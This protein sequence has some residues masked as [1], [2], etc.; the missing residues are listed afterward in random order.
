LQMAIVPSS[1]WFV[2]REVAEMNRNAIQQT[3][4]YCI[5]CFNQESRSLVI[6]TDEGGIYQIPR[7][8]SSVFSREGGP[9]M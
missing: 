3:S 7:A 1:S 2:A 5:P 8:S 6:H 9:S 4:P